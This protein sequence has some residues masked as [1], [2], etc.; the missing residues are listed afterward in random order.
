MVFSRRLFRDYKEPVAPKAPPTKP[1]AR[2]T[3]KP[4]TIQLAPKP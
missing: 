1:G 4:E 3:P 2:P